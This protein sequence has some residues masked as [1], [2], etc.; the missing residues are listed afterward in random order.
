MAQPLVNGVVHN[1]ASISVLVAGVP[2]YS[3]SSV[4]YKDM[5]EVENTQ[6]MGYYSVGRS[7]GAITYEASLTMQLGDALK[8]QD[9]ATDGRVQSLPPFD[10][11]V[12]FQPFG[13]TNVVVHTLKDCTFTEFGIDTSSGDMQIDV[14]LPMQVGFI[15][16]KPGAQPITN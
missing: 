6:G 13:S 12:T 5:Q 1:F 2:L 16:F 15:A 3:I 11:V 10:V 4:S 14:E 7:Y 9:L 8:L